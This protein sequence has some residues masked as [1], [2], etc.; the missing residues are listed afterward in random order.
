MIPAHNESAGIRRCLDAL[1]AGVAP[2][3]LDVLVVCNGC[4]DDTAALARS[5]GHPVR[6][7]ELEAASKPAALRAGD[8]LARALPRIYLDADVV[9]HGSAACVLLER[10]RAGAVAARPPIHYASSASSAPVR[11]YYRARSQL[12]A[13]LGSLWGAGVYGLS[14]AGRSRFDAFPDVVADDLWVDRQFAP[15]EI[16]IVDCPPVEVAVPRRARDLLRVLR[17]TYRG[18]AETAGVDPHGRGRETTV[19]TLQQLRRVAA[20]GP[21]AALDAATYAAFAV[22]ARLALAAPLSGVRWERDDSSRTR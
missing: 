10:L 8:A 15:A 22:S 17:R 9:L 20:A 12:P 4:G 13:L 3:E 18:K 11:S 14:E 2:E 7:I 1:F 5:S 6:V 19:S 21:H 16:E